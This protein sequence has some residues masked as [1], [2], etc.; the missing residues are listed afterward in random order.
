MANFNFT[1]DTDPMA[2]EITT[3][4]KHVNTVSGS[5]IAMQA[6]V[7]KAEKDGADL[8]CSNVNKGFYSLIQSQI[9][10]KIAALTSQV[11]AKL[12]DLSQQ[13]MALNAIKTRMERDYHMISGRYL[14]LFNSLNNALYSRITE[15]DKPVVRLIHSDMVIS[16]N[17]V[18]GNIASIATNQNESISDSQMILTSK[19]KSDGL[20][21]LNSMYEYI[22]DVNLQKQQS[23]AVISNVTVNDVK[24]VYLPF[25]ITESTN[26]LGTLTIKSY[27]P[28][29]NIGSIDGI[30]TKS[31]QDKANSAIRSGKWEGID[32]NDKY[33]IDCQFEEILLASSVEDRV[34]DTISR[35]YNECSHIRQLKKS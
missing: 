19:T 1:V 24:V 21:A 5:V 27:T 30:V 6:A 18:K 31:A 16:D 14:K 20:V 17:R 23:E 28:T 9:S 34:K 13:A 15:I 35:M 26:E 3:V 4:S 25:L 29:S 12:M 8:V 10:Q 11:E 7:V 2:R 22:R 33:S 32:P